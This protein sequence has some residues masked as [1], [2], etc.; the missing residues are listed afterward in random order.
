MGEARRTG[1]RTSRVLK[2]VI[3]TILKKVCDGRNELDSCQ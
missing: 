1:N 2:P 3:L